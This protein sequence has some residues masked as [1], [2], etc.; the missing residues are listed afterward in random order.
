MGKV[1]QGWPA[2]RSS[3]GLGMISSW[4]TEAAP[5]RWAVPTQSAPVSPPPMTTTCLPSALIGA[6]VDV[7]LFHLELGDA[8]AEE[9][10]DTVR[11]LV[12]GDGVSGP[13]QLLGGGQA[14]G[15]GADDGDGL[16]GEALGGL[17]GDVPVVPRLVD[18]GDLDVL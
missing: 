4:V 1:G 8:V 11:A 15:A 10:A 5:W 13:R 14:G 7:A 16:A 12:D 2:L 17:R 3:P 9:S 6:A 18:D